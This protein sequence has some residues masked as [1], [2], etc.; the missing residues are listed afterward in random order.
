MECWVEAG[1][2][3]SSG[4]AGSVYWGLGEGFDWV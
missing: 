2:V 3:S 4:D 1:V